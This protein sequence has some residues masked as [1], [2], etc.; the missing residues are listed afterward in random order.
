MEDKG[1]L[2]C[3]DGKK[4]CHWVGLDA[5]CWKYHDEEWGRCFLQDLDDFSIFE[6]L[7]LELLQAGLSWRLILHKRD[8]F[9]G[10]FE[11][12]D[13][14][15]IAA[16][17]LEKQ[18]ILA[19]D[20]RLIRHYGKISAIIHNAQKAILLQKER[21]SLF[22][23]FLQ[24]KALSKVDSLIFRPINQNKASVLLAQDLKKRGWKFIGPVTSYAFLQSIGFIKAHQPGCDFFI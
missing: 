5:R 7:C 2:L 10:A 18:N 4:R 13:F 14:Y 17:N 11:N 9:R 1:L 21:G 12:F 23:Y 20:S 19:Q 24:F 15:K 8:N 16:Y 3:S 6:K 22:Q